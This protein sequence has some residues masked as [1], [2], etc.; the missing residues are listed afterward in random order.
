MKYDLIIRNGTV[1]HSDEPRVED[2]AVAEGKIVEYMVYDTDGT[3]ADRFTY[4]YDAK[5]NKIEEAFYTWTGKRSRRW[6]C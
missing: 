1:V 2:I 6:S 5:G 4:Q 3:V